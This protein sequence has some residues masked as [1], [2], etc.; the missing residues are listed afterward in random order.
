MQRWAEKLDREIVYGWIPSDYTPS[1][2]NVIGQ[3]I[4][5]NL[6]P[7]AVLSSELIKRNYT[8]E[9]IKIRI[10]ETVSSGY[11]D[12]IPLVVLKG[13]QA[14]PIDQKQPL[15]NQ[16]KEGDY[17]IVYQKQNL[18]SSHINNKD[19]PQKELEI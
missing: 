13:K 1:I 3:P 12:A 15:E 8:I 2:T 10:G 16:I 9:T 5:G 6:E 4:F 11:P 17:L 19:K 7:P 14:K 18:K